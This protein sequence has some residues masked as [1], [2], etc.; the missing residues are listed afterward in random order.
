[1][2]VIG[3]NIFWIELQEKSNKEFELLCYCAMIS[4]HFKLIFQTYFKPAV[5]VLVD[6]FVLFWREADHKVGFPDS[7]SLMM[8]LVL[9]VFAPFQVNYGQKFGDETVDIKTN[10]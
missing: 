2:L 5:E 10:Y 4:A 1:M 8:G 7:Q 3:K 9:V 6:C